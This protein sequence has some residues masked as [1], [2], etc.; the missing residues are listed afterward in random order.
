MKKKIYEVAINRFFNIFKML[1]HAFSVVMAYSIVF[2]FSELFI[3]YEYICIFISVSFLVL[4]EGLVFFSLNEAL[5]QSLKGIMNVS[6]LLA[7]FSI[8][9]ICFS[10]LLTTLGTG[11]VA[12]SK[13]KK[14]DAKPLKQT[15]TSETKRLNRFIT[16]QGLI[17]SNLQKVQLSRVDNNGKKTYFLRG[18]ERNDLKSASDNIKT[19]NKEL[20]AI[21]NRTRLD[22]K[23]IDSSNSELKSSINEKALGFGFALQIALVL[24][25]MFHHYLTETK[26]ENPPKQAETTVYKD[27]ANNSNDDFF[28]EYKPVNGVDLDILKMYSSDKYPTY[29][30]IAD[31]LNVKRGQVT[32]TIQNFNKQAFKYLINKSN[33]QTA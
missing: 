8:A 19:A 3:P 5:E 20:I 10:A 16:S 4:I 23:E 32:D 11:N 13:Y 9:I 12:V 2:E 21:N 1:L 26:I 31:K 33:L 25:T 24:L 29:Q 28:S 7:V 30:P 14:H 17:I 27:N 15:E 6:G 22:N 18:N